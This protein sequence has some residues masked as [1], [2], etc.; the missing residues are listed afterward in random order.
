MKGSDN[1]AV[2]NNREYAWDSTTVALLEMFHNLDLSQS[3]PCHYSQ[4]L[5]RAPEAQSQ[6]EREN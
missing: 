2:I 3:T 4:H 1:V 6:V 5:I